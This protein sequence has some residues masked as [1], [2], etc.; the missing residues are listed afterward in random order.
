MFNCI[1][2]QTL[3]PEQIKSFQITLAFQHFKDL[4]AKCAEYLN[5]DVQL[6][7]DKECNQEI[8][9]SLSLCQASLRNIIYAKRVYDQSYFPK[10]TCWFKQDGIE[11]NMGVILNSDL[12][13][14]E[15]LEEAKQKDI[16]VQ[17]PQ[18][19]IVTDFEQTKILASMIQLQMCKLVNPQDK[20]PQLIIHFTTTGQVPQVQLQQKKFFPQFPFPQNPPRPLA[21]QGTLQ[22]SG[23]QNQKFQFPI[24][25]LQTKPQNL[26]NNNK[27]KIPENAGFPA[28]N[29]EIQNNQQPP[30]AQPFMNPFGNPP[31]NNTVPFQNMNTQVFQQKVENKANDV[32]TL[33]RM[34]LKCVE[35]M[36]LVGKFILIINENSDF[37]AYQCSS[38]QLSGFFLQVKGKKGSLKN[39]Q[40][41]KWESKY[42]VQIAD[43]L[44]K[45]F[46]IKWKNNTYNSLN[47][48]LM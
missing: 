39:E 14:E 42:G 46:I 5:Y 35:Q 22:P 33:E 38:P 45:G 21:N 9:S 40:Q 2:V 10:V 7:L 20:D 6:F 29:F 16:I 3:P 32:T 8:D 13:F 15:V 47:I 11:L 23:L 19:I 43:N 48:Q 30:K 27:V 28:S 18:S 34:A 1:T 24:F 41:I 37:V 12:S 17:M 25:S 36:I 31:N 26:I 4:L 44:G